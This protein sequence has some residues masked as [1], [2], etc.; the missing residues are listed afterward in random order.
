MNTLLP[1][2][3]LTLDC[4]LLS[5]GLLLAR[6]EW[7]QTSPAYHRLASQTTT[8]F[9]FSDKNLTTKYLAEYR[10]QVTLSC[11]ICE[12][13]GS[14]PSP[15]PLPFLTPTT[16]AY[17][18][19]TSGTTGEPVTV[20]VPHCCIVPNIVDLRGWFSC[21]QNDVIFNAAPLTFDPSV[22]EVCYH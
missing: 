2:C 6:L 9:D 5:A 7:K 15:W 22:V 12:R 13:V 10:E 19:S 16:L 8:A 21:G 20:R 18:L 17:I 3:V 4:Q 1:L 11:P 14:A